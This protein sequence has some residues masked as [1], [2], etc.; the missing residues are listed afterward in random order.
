LITFIITLYTLPLLPVSHGR[1]IPSP[2]AGIMSTLYKNFLFFVCLFRFFLPKFIHTTA[3]LHRTVLFGF[4]SNAFFNSS[5]AAPSQ[6]NVNNF[7]LL[8]LLPWSSTS[9]F[10][11]WRGGGGAC[12]SVFC[13]KTGSVGEGGGLQWPPRRVAKAFVDSLNGYTKIIKL[14]FILQLF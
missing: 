5:N 11:W 2:S 6:P 10:L 7:L 3:F 14:Y 9:S 8:L 12:C 13:A 1:F 4:D